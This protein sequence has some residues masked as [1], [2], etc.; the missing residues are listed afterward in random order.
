MRKNH[1]VSACAGVAVLA[2]QLSL[3]VLAEQRLAHPLRVA[4]DDGNDHTQHF[5][6]L[7]GGASLLTE[8]VAI[9]APTDA[10][11]APGQPQ[12]RNL[13]KLRSIAARSARTDSIV[14]VHSAMALD[15]VAQRRIRLALSRSGNNAEVVFID[16][17]KSVDCGTHSLREAPDPA[18]YPNPL[19]RKR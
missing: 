16:D 11:L 19:S 13:E 8:A 15:R 2:L 6:T 5:V 1:V 7:S 3:P 12:A 18:R 9:V 10:A 17:E 14:T 4:I